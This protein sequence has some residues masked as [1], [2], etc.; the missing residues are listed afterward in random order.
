MSEWPEFVGSMPSV[1]EKKLSQQTPKSNDF[2]VITV[3]FLS[4]ACFLV[5]PAYADIDMRSTGIFYGIG[6]SLLSLAILGL[7][8]DLSRNRAAKTPE[9]TDNRTGLRAVWGWGLM[10]LRICL[11]TLTFWL[12]LL[13]FLTGVDIFYG[14]GFATFL[15]AIITTITYQANSRRVSSSKRSG[16]A[17]TETNTITPQQKQASSGKTAIVFLLFSLCLLAFPKILKIDDLI[18]GIFYGIGFT[19]LLMT[20][21]AIGVGIAKRVAGES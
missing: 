8:S 7:C 10:L 11:F 16:M 13:A 4:S 21:A 12:C 9:T 1:P 19:V 20:M 18:G 17:I 14:I 5:F 6:L 3:L 2:S 15:L